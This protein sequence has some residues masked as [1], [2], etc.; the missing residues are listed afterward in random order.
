MS[1]IEVQLPDGSTR[2]LVDGATALDLAT[3][4]GPRLAKD[5][6]AAVVDGQLTDLET[7]GDRETVS[8]VTPKSELG[9]E[10]LRHSSAHVLAQAVTRLWPGPSTQ[11]ARYRGRVLLRLRPTWWRALQ[12]RRL[13]AHRPGDA[14][15]SE[16]RPTVPA[17]GVLGGRRLG[18]L[19]RPALQTRDHQRGL[20]HATPEDL[21]EV[22]SASVVSTY[23]NSPSFVDLC[24]GPHVPSTSHLGHFKLT[25]VAG[26]YW[27][28]DENAR[29]SSASTAPPGSPKRRWPRTCIQLEEAELRDH[30]KSGS[31]A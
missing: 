4:I 8:I 22:A 24:R 13:R 5:A 29:N 1:D 3:Q 19:R 31:G 6:L 14:R 12:R 20:V 18:A 27:R 9:R 7:A 11:S 26:A 10:V 28:G 16:G 17:F 2:T 30:R 21:A 25:R 23:S 15:H